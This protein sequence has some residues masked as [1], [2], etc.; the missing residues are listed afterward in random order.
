MIREIAEKHKAL[1]L[2]CPVINR[3]TL[4]HLGVELA[5][6]DLL[7]MKSLSTAKKYPKKTVLAYAN[8]KIDRLMFLQS[9]LVRIVDIG[10]DGTEK[11]FQY[12]AGGCFLAEAAF[13]HQQPILYDIQCLEESEVL[14]IDRCHLPRI[15]ERPRLTLFLITSTSLSSRILAMQIEDAAFRTSEEKICRMLLCLSGD[16]YK[17][18]KLSFTHQELADLTGVHRVNVT[19]TLNNLKKEGIISMGARGVI[20]VIDFDKL[21]RRQ[22]SPR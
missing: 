21:Q 7:L 16:D 2:S 14:Y 1:L 11:T 3:I 17:Q 15:L 18:N 9:G 12:I 20:E 22:T 5:N 13:F 19:N 6:D 4:A 10:M 8:E